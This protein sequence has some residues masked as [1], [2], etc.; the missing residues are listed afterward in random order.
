MTI[1]DK[2]LLELS[3]K[4]VVED[5]MPDFTNEKHLLALNEVLVDLNWSM[6]ARSELLYTLMEADNNSER[7]K[8]MKKVIKFK[9]EKG[10]DDEITVGGALKQ[11]EDHPAHKK[12]KQMVGNEKSGE[13]ETGDGDI[14]KQKGS[15]DRDSAVNKGGETGGE[16][17]PNPKIEKKKR[18]EARIEADKQDYTERE[19]KRKKSKDPRKTTNT[20]KH[21]D[22][23]NNQKAE[24]QN[25]IKNE[26]D[27]EKKTIL[28]ED[29]VHVEKRIKKL[30]GI[31]TKQIKEEK[32]V[33]V[34]MKDKK[35]LTKKLSDSEREVRNSIDINDIN[36]TDENPR[37][38]EERRIKLNEKLEKR[39]NEIYLGKDL[40]A[41]TAGSTT[42]EMGGGMAAED[43][44]NDMEV[45]KE[46]NVILK[47][48]GEV[49]SEEEYEKRWMEREKA[50]IDEAK[51]LRKKICDKKKG[52]ACDELV[53]EWL[54]VAYRTGRNEVHQLMNNPDYQAKKPQPE[55][56]P[57]GH[58]MDYN[59]QALVQNELQ[60]RLKEAEEAGDT[61]AIKHYKRQLEKLE[62]LKE[63]DTG[64]LYEDKDGRL[65][66]KHTSNKKSEKDPHYNKSIQSK[67]ASM[68]ESAK[69][70][71]KECEFKSGEEKKKCQEETKA[72]IKKIEET[73][74]KGSKTVYDGDRVVGAD[75]REMDKDERK[76]LTEGASLLGNLPSRSATK[77]DDYAK[78][79]RKRS[80]DYKKLHDECK[81]LHGEQPWTDEQ[82]MEA[83]LQIME[84]GDRVTVNADEKKIKEAGEG[85]VVDLGNGKYGKLI[86]GVPRA[87]DKDGNP[88]F[89]VKSAKLLYKLSE[90]I[91]T[92]RGKAVAATKPKGW[93]KDRWP[94]KGPPYEDEDLERLGQEYDPALTLEQMKWI[95][96]SPGADKIAKAND[97]RKVANDGAHQDVVSDIQNQDATLDGFEPRPPDNHVTDEEGNNGPATQLYVDSFMEDM[98]WNRYIDGDHD[99]VGDMSINGQNVQPKH[100]RECLAKLSG[101]SPDK[102]GKEKDLN[103]P[104]VRKGLKQ[105][106]KNK[107]R[108]SARKADNASDTDALTAESRDAHISFDS[109][110]VDEVADTRQGR[111]EN[112]TR[113]VSVGEERFRS[114][115]V[116]V[117]SVVGGL[118]LDMQECIL[119]KMD[120]SNAVG[121]AE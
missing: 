21:I 61:N 27:P 78:K 108:I 42:G 39:R 97:K 46:G 51:G 53:N 19:E 8:L 96:T 35:P 62:G 11:G 104:E 91:T 92:M 76:S 71:L 4:K 31:L 25:Q 68:Q 64:V 45:D 107:I 7:E 18:Q 29:L 59:N 3:A 69:R 50:K 16:E 82:I 38:P 23:L 52:A 41:G 121:A 36:G 109:G 116:G 94:I 86:D 74:D 84:K 66:F 12:A 5:G 13:E 102:D 88:D 34:K 44:T 55:G 49:V 33:R 118:G 22:D 6:E 120:K 48:D 40:P 17:K 112:A 1:I 101:Y 105:H 24:L 37:T 110:T 15:F 20:Q 117:N 14:T 43:I 103:D 85:V 106:L 73:S 93:P 65:R 98:H 72:A 119:E 28:E 32:E 95:M 70:Q 79:V 26:S 47:W 57:T 75:V 54:K 67:R 89:A 58:V 113:P 90:M 114:K 115:G 9:N 56:R 2:I 63:T 111:E 80:G 83:Q 30:S 81:E 87:C 10:E 100:F 99:G 77:G 60:Q